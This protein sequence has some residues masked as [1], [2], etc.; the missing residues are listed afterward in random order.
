MSRRCL[1]SPLVLR[2]RY[3]HSMLSLPTEAD[4]NW[5]ASS[6]HH[7]GC[8]VV[9]SFLLREAGQNSRESSCGWKRVEESKIASNAEQLWT[10][11]IHLSCIGLYSSAVITED[12]FFQKILMSKPCRIFIWT[13]CCLS[14][15]QGRVQ[16]DLVRANSIWIA[17]QFHVQLIW[18]CIWTWQ[19]PNFE[20]CTLSCTD[21]T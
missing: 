12:N 3:V 2:S 17:L 7:I 19:V 13:D 14:A 1:S 16:R 4:G 15:K 8:Y 20:A 9:E 11:W 18:Q 10:L 5:P 6:H 21:L